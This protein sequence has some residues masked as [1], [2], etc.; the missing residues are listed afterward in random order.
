MQERRVIVVAGPP[1]GGKTTWVAGQRK[2]G[3]VV[4]DLDA[5]VGAL[6]LGDWYGEGRE[7]VLSLALAVWGYLVAAVK[8]GQH[9]GTAWVVTAAPLAE[10]RRIGDELGA[11]VVVVDPG[12][13]VARRQAGLDGRRGGR[14]WGREIGEWYAAGR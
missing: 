9:G 4:V 5:L 6:T 3:D 7:G 2:P 12:E 11:R 10:A 1:A 8:A 13:A 14:D